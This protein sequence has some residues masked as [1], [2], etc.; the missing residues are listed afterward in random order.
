MKN[1]APIWIGIAV[2]VLVGGAYYLGQSSKNSTSAV[3]DVQTTPIVSPV[4][5]STSTEKPV[6]QKQTSPTD[7]LMTASANGLACKN[8]AYAAVN[9]D[10]AQKKQTNPT[11]RVTL[12]QTH[13]SQSTGNCYYEVSILDAGDN[14]T[15]I[16]VAPN[17]DWLAYCSSSSGT[18]ICNEHHHQGLETEAQFHQ[19]E[20]FYLTN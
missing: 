13:Y 10:D 2:I 9:A 8:I 1:G 14:E 4:D 6:P 19:L 5:T 17:D 12:L 18:I 16:R 11:A 15:Q 20:T 7:A 3:S